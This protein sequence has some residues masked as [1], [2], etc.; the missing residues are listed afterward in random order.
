MQK[1]LNTDKSHYHRKA[2][3]MNKATLKPIRA[4]DVQERHQIDLIDMGRKEL[5]KGMVSYT[6][7]CLQRLI[8]L[9]ALFGF[10]L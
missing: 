4:K 8:F 2:K 3:F 6:D 1:V 9:A 5:L 10:A 7:T